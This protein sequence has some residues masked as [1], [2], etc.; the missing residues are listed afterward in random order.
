MRWR[1][2]SG[3]VLP[4]AYGPVYFP[5]NPEPNGA[6]VFDIGGGQ[7][8][9]ADFKLEGH[10]VRQIRGTLSNMPQ[11]RQ[12]VMRLVRSGD[13]LGNRAQVNLANG[14]FG[15]ADVTPG[16][17]V[18]QAYTQDAAPV[19]MVEVPVIVGDKDLT[20]VKIALNPAVDV[21]V[22]V[23]APIQADDAGGRV[24]FRR[25][26]FLQAMPMDPRVLPRGF[27]SARA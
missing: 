15:V 14:V 10:A 22:R 7:T 1:R 17:Y 9:I 6:R 4:E 26:V 24:S 8:V 23:E 18:L 21:N 5:N 19:L 2:G 27:P 25:T 16:A 3:G 12:I 20:G 11:R 13:A